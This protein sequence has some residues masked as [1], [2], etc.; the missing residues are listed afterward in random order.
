MLDAT[1]EKVRAK[2]KKLRVKV[3]VLYIY[4][5]KLGLLMGYKYAV[6]GLTKT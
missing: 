4:T 2:E 5:S 3:K 6:G 1:I